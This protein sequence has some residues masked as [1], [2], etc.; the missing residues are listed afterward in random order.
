LPTA[1]I[2]SVQR[3]IHNRLIAAAINENPDQ[4]MKPPLPVRM[5]NKYPGL[6]AVIGYAVAIGPLPEHAPAFARRAPV[7]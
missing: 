2:Q 6:G 7:S 3:V 1:L 5:I 4:P